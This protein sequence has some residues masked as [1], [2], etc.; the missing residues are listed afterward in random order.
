M[1]DTLD[2]FL[3][4]DERAAVRA[5]I[6]AASPLP[7]IAYTSREFFALEVERIFAP[8]WVAVGYAPSVAQPGDVHPM[9]IFGW[10]IV[11]LRGDDGE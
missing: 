4:A 2:R 3:G 11:M 6:E 7:N 8:N 10:P 5:P 9:T 1:S